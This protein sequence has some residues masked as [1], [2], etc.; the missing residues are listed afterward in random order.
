MKNRERLFSII[1]LS[2]FFLS[3]LT[4]WYRFL[5]LVTT[6]VLVVMML[7]KMGRGIV[8]RETMA[9]HT[10]FVCLTMPLVG[11]V[12][13]GQDFEL[14]RLW[15]K[16]MQVPEATYF[17][18]AVPSTSGFCAAVC[19]PLTKRNEADQGA[20]LQG[21]L[22]RAKLVLKHIPTMGL[23]LMILGIVC[24]LLAQ[25]A[26]GVLQFAFYLFFLASFSGFLYV[27]FSP[28]IKKKVFILSLFALLIF[29]NALQSGMFTII[30]YMGITMISFLFVGKKI[31]FLKKISVFVLGLVMLFLLQ[32]VKH[33]YRAKTWSG[34]Y[35]GS[36]ASLFFSLIGDQFSSKKERPFV[37]TFFPIYA[38]GNQGFNISLVM[39]RIPYRQDFDGGT[40][41]FYS[42]LSSFVP[43]I[44]WPDKPE[45]GGKFNMRFYAGYIIEG[46]STNVGPLGEAY[47]SFGVIGGIIY[48][49]ILGWAVRWAYKVVFRIGYKI[50]LLIFWL[51]LIFY[52]ITYSAESD[53]LQITNS[54]IKSG[55]FVFLVYK[56]WP[57]I[58]GVAKNRF[59]LSKR[60]LQTMRRELA[61]K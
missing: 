20:L 1:L 61:H 60:G 39:Q 30:A 13:Y 34:T 23:M 26:P 32:S 36:K 28:G 59:G 3:I 31:S 11:Y 57:G 47:G 27:Y 52:Q 12:F 29:A 40:N 33:G 38:R 55:F 19:W 45:A 25:V 18:F 16:Y 7:D 56:I 49:V 41:L 35:E 50:P 46:W 14:S 51:P 22:E 43:R 21:L 9:L 53:T 24:H 17:G 10:C 58:F 42:F 6:A 2:V 44:F 54:V 37:E 5:V 48:M 4:D 15:V 8:L